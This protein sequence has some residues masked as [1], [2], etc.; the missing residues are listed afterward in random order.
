[1]EANQPLSKASPS[2]DEIRLAFI[3]EFSDPSSNNGSSTHEWEGGQPFS[4]C[5]YGKIPALLMKTKTSF[6]RE[7]PGRWDFGKKDQ[8]Y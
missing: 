8:P 7:F 4:L 2:K 1:M 3:W 6:T 5:L